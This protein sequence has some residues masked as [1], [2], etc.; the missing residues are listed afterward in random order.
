MVLEGTG[1]DTWK[2]ESSTF[3]I[4]ELLLLLIKHL[5][6]I[7]HILQVPSDEVELAY[8]LDGVGELRKDLKP[9]LVIYGHFLQQ[10]LETFYV[11]VVELHLLVLVLVDQ[12]QGLDEVLLLL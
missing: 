10:S 5:Q 4:P 3:K 12:S 2:V 9:H 11:G 6:S 8:G 1:V 7:H